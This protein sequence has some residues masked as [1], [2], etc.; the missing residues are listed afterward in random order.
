MLLRNQ[1]K[2]TLYFLIGL[3]RSEYSEIKLDF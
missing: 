1:F 3:L 2:I